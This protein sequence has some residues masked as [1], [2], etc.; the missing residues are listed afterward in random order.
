MMTVPRPEE[1]H[2]LILDDLSPAEYVGARFT[3][4]GMSGLPAGS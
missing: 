2:R 3:R 1:L 4:P